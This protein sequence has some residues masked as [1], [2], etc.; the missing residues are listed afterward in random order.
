[1]NCFIRFLIRIRLVQIQV[2]GSVSFAR[3]G[4]LRGNGAG[5]RK[6]W[7]RRSDG[8]SG[9]G[10]DW[11][12][13][14]VSMRKVDVGKVLDAEFRKTVQDGTHIDGLGRR[15]RGWNEAMSSAKGLKTLVGSSM[16]FE[17][18]EREL[19]PANSTAETVV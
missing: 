12:G 19:T 13:V 11:A 1:M 18:S 16:K 9:A 3:I 4:T 14:S 5:I 15:G 10:S 6:R 8:R 7:R 2:G 17:S